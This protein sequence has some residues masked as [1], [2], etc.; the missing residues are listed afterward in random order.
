MTLA[1][2]IESQAPPAAPAKSRDGDTGGGGAF[3][4]VLA[5]QDQPRIAG[6]PRPAGKPEIAGATKSVARTIHTVPVAPDLHGA[7]GAAAPGRPAGL[8]SGV[9]VAGGTGTAGPSARPPLAVAGL[10]AA[11]MPAGAP[12]V[13]VAFGPVPLPAGHIG[14][15]ART[16]Q[17]AAP[18]RDGLADDGAATPGPDA[19]GADGAGADLASPTA[20]VPPGPALPAPMPVGAAAGA[21]IVPVARDGRAGA[22]PATVAGIG[23]ATRTPAH[24]LPGG[25][26]PVTATAASDDAPA[27]VAGSTGPAHPSA[28][29]GLRVRVSVTAAEPAAVAN[30]APGETSDLVADA[31]TSAANPAA[32]AAAAPGV[33]GPGVQGFAETVQAT[34]GPGLAPG[35]IPLLAGAI[36]ALPTPGAA[37]PAEQ[38]VAAVTALAAAGPRP[39]VQAAPPRVLTIQL[40]PDELGRVHIRIDRTIDGGARIDLTADRPD[41][42]H[43]LRGDQPALHRA[44]DAAG[45][46]PDARVVRFHLADAAT[47]LPPVDAPPP[48]AFAGGGSFGQAPQHDAQNRAAV[49]SATADAPWSPAMP[50][51]VPAATRR[52][53]ANTSRVDITA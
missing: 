8:Q 13:T 36:P 33:P 45:I 12:P 27:A 48:Q 28:P 49:T 29:A 50:D 7:P 20:A 38:V 39:D 19:A 52:A 32:P 25:A 4:D 34:A 16:G 37:P 42:L 47:A 23:P 51:P 9:A 15:P 14:L 10:P 18:V 35:P 30:G 1:I 11:P 26:V 5:G 46:G 41:T 6:R 21:V 40:N 43:L 17:S 31:P 22:A 53:R 44:L 3:A 24:A 2:P